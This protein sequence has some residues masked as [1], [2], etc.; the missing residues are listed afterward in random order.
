MSLFQN[1]QLSFK[2][3]IFLILSTDVMRCLAQIED[4]ITLQDL[5]NPAR[6][7]MVKLSMAYGIA[8]RFAGAQVTDEEVYEQVFEAGGAQI[9]SFAI[10]G[11]LA[12][13]IPPS[14]LQ[15]SLPGKSDTA[16]KKPRRPTKN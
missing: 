1:V 15:K 2:G 6:V 5:S 13:M 9:V 10:Q 11:L 12:L 7:P 8:L 3:S 14:K 16:T 4:V